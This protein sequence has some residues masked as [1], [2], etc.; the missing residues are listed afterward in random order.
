MPNYSPFNGVLPGDKLVPRAKLLGD[1]EI[2][3]VCYTAMLLMS[4]NDLVI[5]SFYNFPIN[6]HRLF[7]QRIFDRVCLCSGIANRCV[8]DDVLIIVS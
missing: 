7:W 1:V 6:R 2:S 5:N 3:D 8:Y 4:M